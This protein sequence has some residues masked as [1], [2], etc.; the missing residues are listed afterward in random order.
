[1]L[2]TREGKGIPGVTSVTRRGPGTGAHLLLGRTSKGGGAL[3]FVQRKGRNITGVQLL[4]ANGGN[5]V[6]RLVS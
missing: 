1:M 5:A 2:A 6:S 4:V 3:I